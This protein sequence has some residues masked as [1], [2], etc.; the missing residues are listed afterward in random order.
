MDAPRRRVYAWHMVRPRQI[1]MPTSPPP[2]VD[3]RV[4]F[5]DVPWEQY[6]AL[7]A[8]R[9][10][11]ALPRLTY[12]DGTLEIMSPSTKHEEWKK[13]IARLV[14][15]HCDEARIPLVGL[16]STTFRKKA[17]RGGLEPDECYCI[18]E[19]KSVPDIAIEVVHT[20]GGLDKLAVYRKLGVPEVWFWSKG[21]FHLFA[22]SDG[23][24]QSCDASGF[25]PDLDFA[26]LGAI[27]AGT[28]PGAQPQAVWE[29]RAGLRRRRG[30]G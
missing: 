30:P 24:Y 11:K 2:D 3:Q 26:T 23:E 14:E 16:G 8:A 22:L 15:A 28:E 1:A 7:D 19:A 18:G 9:G 12:L 25:V 27:V 13:L 4:I 17:K 10:E 21:R 6:R 29:Y 5:H 20:G